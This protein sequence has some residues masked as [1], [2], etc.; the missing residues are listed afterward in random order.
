MLLRAMSAQHVHGAVH[1]QPDTV[2]RSNVG[3]TRSHLILQGVI[4]VWIDGASG[5]AVGRQGSDE[6]DSWR[7][8]LNGMVRHNL[9]STPN[10]E[11][12][13]GGDVLAECAAFD[14]DATDS[15]LH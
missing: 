8:L 10:F 11:V 13:E 1:F 6:L 7:P 15:D 14:A 5:V 3:E 4:D 12:I 9:G 2:H